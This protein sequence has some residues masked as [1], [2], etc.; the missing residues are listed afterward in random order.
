MGKFMFNLGQGVNIVGTTCFAFVVL[1]ID[2][3]SKKN[4]NGRNKYM[5][6]ADKTLKN[7]FNKLYDETELM[8]CGTV[9]EVY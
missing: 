6:S 4:P 1:R 8:Y 9:G 3:I 5:L 7:R 2:I